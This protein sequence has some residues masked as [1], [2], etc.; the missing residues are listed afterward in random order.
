MVNRMC[1]VIIYSLIIIV[2]DTFPV[3]IAVKCRCINY[4]E[5]LEK[6]INVVHEPSER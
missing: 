5:M 1:T 4:S 6:H 3:Y 2:S